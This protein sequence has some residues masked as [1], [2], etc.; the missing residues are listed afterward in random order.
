MTLSVHI[1]SRKSHARH[2]KIVAEA[3]RTALILAG[4]EQTELTVV[5]TSDTEVRELNR[6][7]TGVDVETDVLAFPSGSADLDSG[8]FYLGDVIIAVPVAERQAAAAG[9][10]LQDELALLTVHGVLHLLGHDHHDAA[11]RR[12]MEAAQRAVL[13]R[14]G[15]RLRQ[16]S[17]AA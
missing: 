4:T 11:S 3:A 14:M 7:H 17:E 10:S 1:R 5:L 8:L 16:P 15:I 13:R 9:H 2:A 6:R 12:E